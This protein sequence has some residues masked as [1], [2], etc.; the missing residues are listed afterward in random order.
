MMQRSMTV[1]AGVLR[2]AAS[3]AATADVVAGATTTGAGPAAWELANLRTVATGLLAAATARTES[4]GC[5]TRAD[6]PA[7]DP[8]LALR[9]VVS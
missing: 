1:G 5:H 4:R 6:H 3:L 8:E 9:L 2:D 7:T